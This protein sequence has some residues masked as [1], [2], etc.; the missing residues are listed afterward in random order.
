MN[1]KTR[2]FI[3]IEFWNKT[4][5]QNVHNYGTMLS[6]FITC[7]GGI[8]KYTTR[9]SDRY[10]GYLASSSGESDS[11]S[12][13]DNNNESDSSTETNSDSNTTMTLIMTVRV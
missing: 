13:N 6:N 1:I 9:N 11:N 10:N 7:V 5:S 8:Q 4:N 3:K 2:K 12:D